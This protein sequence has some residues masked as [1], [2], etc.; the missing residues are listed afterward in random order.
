MIL[1][2]HLG[3]IHSNSQSFTKRILTKDRVSDFTNSLH[4]VDWNIS[5]LSSYN[6][7]EF[8]VWLFGLLQNMVN[9]HFPLRKVH[10]KF[11][12]VPWFTNR[13]RELRELLRISHTLFLKSGGE[14]LWSNYCVARRNY[15]KAIREEKQA[16]YTDLI[17]NSDNMTKTVWQIVNNERKQSKASSVN[18]ELSAEEFNVYFT[19]I[20][21]NILQKNLIHV[22]FIGVVLDSGLNWHDHITYTCS[23]IC[24][25][26]FALRQLS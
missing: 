17:L 25:Q 10:N 2:D 4:T 3:K 7:N 1:P 24:P 12:H 26:M 6:S 14:T 9:N 21:D 19:S 5:N 13:L 22:N 8:S 20:T 15:R 16:S 18:T 11:S 23:R